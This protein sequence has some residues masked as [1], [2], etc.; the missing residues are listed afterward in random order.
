MLTW[1][2]SE[3]TREENKG[4]KG[5]ISCCGLE[6]EADTDENAKSRLCFT[7]K[8]LSGSTTR[9]IELECDSSAER[10][11]WDLSLPA[12]ARGASAPALPKVLFARVRARFATTREPPNCWLWSGARLPMRA[13]IV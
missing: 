13:E 11:E 1:Y 5:W 6:I 4:E 2:A 3:Q 12:T 9:R 10:C 7:V 8:A